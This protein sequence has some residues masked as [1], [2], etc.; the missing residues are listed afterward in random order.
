MRGAVGV[1]NRFR[2]SLLRTGA[3]LGGGFGL[4]K[5]AKFIINTNRQFEKL[6]AQLI[7]MQGSAAG[8]TKAFKDIEALA[9]STPFQIEELAEAFILLRTLAVK[10]TSES[11]TSLGNLASSMGKKIT[12]VSRAVRSLAAGSIEPIQQLGLRASIAGEQ[13]NLSFKGMEVT[14]D[15]TG[16]AIVDGL[17]R[18]SDA[19]FAGAMAREMDTLNGIISNTQ[20]NLGIIAR[21]IGESIMPAL[22]TWAAAIRDVASGQGGFVQNVVRGIG[23]IIIQMGKAIE[24]VSNHPI[25]AEGG[26]VGLLLFGGKKAAVFAAVGAALDEIRTALFGSTTE[27]GK[28]AERVARL[29]D[30]LDRSKRAVDAFNN[31]VEQGMPLGKAQAKNY[32][33][34]GRR[35]AELTIQL[36][37]AERTLD[38]YTDRTINQKSALEGLGQQFIL[39]GQG[40]K[41]FTLDLGKVPGGT[42]GVVKAV[43]GMVGEVQEELSI[44]EEAG[45]TAGRS[46]IRGLIRGIDDMKSFLRNI[47]D[48]VAEDLIIGGLEK[49]L[50]ISS[51][52]RVAAQ[53][54][55]QTIAGFIG[56]M[57]DAAQAVPGAVV[58]SFALAGAGNGGGGNGG[59]GMVVNQTINFSPSFVDGASG[60]A[61]LRANRGTIQGIMRE[62]AQDAG[63]IRGAFG[64]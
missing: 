11:M 54:G 37:L 1:Q 12:D 33:I 53:I 27:F 22:K 2:Q 23:T 51:P 18:I 25:M 34:A 38:G 35:V 10:P 55:R 63:S 41:T 58:S 6:N 13:V 21:G 50:G 39:M 48:Q 16:Q 9:S 57:K 8:A 7:T 31:Q 5:A 59:G 43:G 49:K 32:E 42:K 19:N 45:A 24:F 17:T 20:D 44:L 29:T 3:L 61:W 60:A 62:A 14:V 64:V 56:G 46:L 4:F 52:S 30:E 36:A 28:S 15:R 47:I 40:L 26:L